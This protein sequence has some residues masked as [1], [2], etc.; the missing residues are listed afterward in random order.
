MTDGLQQANTSAGGLPTSTTFSM[1]SMREG[2]RA[3]LTIAITSTRCTPDPRLP[4]P[5]NDARQASSSF[6]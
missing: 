5:V 6:G 2:C 1:I 4:D 3:G